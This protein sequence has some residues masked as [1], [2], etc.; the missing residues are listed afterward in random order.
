MSGQ[1]LPDALEERF[2]TQTELEAEVVL[3]ALEVGLDRWQEWDQGLDLTREI[4]NAVD[5]RV[6]EGLDAEAIPSA[7]E[8]IGHRIP[9]REGEHPPKLLD[10]VGTPLLI[11]PQ[12]N[13]GV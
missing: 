2:A 13:L 8:R 11:C 7:E 6:V 1:E 4:Q 9:E 3:Q 12:G 5:L 10:G